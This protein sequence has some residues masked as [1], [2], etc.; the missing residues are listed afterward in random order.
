MKYLPFGYQEKTQ[1]QLAKQESK[2]KLYDCYGIPYGILDGDSEHI[3]MQKELD[4]EDARLFIMQGKKLPKDLEI[5]L[6]GYK[7]HKYST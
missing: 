7:K 2:F 3:D 4:I 1:E 6:L 5:R